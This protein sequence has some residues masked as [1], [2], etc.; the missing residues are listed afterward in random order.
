[1]ES[2]STQDMA[3]SLSSELSNTGTDTGTGTDW[4]WYWCN[5]DRP[6]DLD[7]AGQHPKQNASH[8]TLPNNLLF[9]M[10]GI[11]PSHLSVPSAI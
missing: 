3:T 9:V 4:Y 1:M 10:S 7:W 6:T 2:C 8:F 11:H 5:T